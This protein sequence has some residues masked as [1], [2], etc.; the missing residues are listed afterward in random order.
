M[1]PKGPTGKIQKRDILT[2]LRGQAGPDG[3]GRMKGPEAEFLDH[4]REGTVHAAA[5]SHRYGRMRLLPALSS[6][7]PTGAGWKRAANATV[8]SRTI[9]RRKRDRGGDYCVAIVTL[10]EGP[11][12]MTRVVGVPPDHVAFGIRL[13]ASVEAAEWA[14]LDHPVV[15]FRPAMAGETSHGA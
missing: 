15:V 10:A 7:R 6:V 8:Y 14:K 12:M 5:E 11:R 1:L 4:L 13:R 2:L 9:I 3:E